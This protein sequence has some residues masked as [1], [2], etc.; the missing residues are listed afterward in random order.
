MHRQENIHMFFFI[1]FFLKIKNNG[2]RSQ[3]VEEFPQWG[4]FIYWSISNSKTLSHYFEIQLCFVFICLLVLV[5]VDTRH[6]LFCLFAEGLISSIIPSLLLDIIMSKK[7]SCSGPH[8][9]LKL[10]SKSLNKS[11]ALENTNAKCYNYFHNH[12]WQLAHVRPD[13]HLAIS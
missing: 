5:K 6:F 2:L 7:K 8:P 3:N 13:L 12:R 4:N 9:I 11:Q 10:I 1:L